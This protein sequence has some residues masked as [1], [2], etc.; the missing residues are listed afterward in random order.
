MTKALAAEV[1]Q[2]QQEN[3]RLQRHVDH[4]ATDP[5]AIEYEAHVRL[6]YMRPGQVAVLNDSSRA[7]QHNAQQVK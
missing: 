6:R 5:G 2:L 1:K 4:L 7:V 3:E